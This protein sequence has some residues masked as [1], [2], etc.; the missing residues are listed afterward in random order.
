[1][2]SRAELLA[3]SPSE[4]HPVAEGAGNAKVTVYCDRLADD[5]VRVVVQTYEPRWW[6]MTARV[7][8]DGF[9]VSATGAFSKLLESDLYDFT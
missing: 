1:M 4:S 3:L 6:G 2:K 5:A 8:A 9:T 7:Q